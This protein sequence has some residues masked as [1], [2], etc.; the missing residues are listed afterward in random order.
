MTFSLSSCLGYVLNTTSISITFWMISVNLMD[1][2]WT[3]DDIERS[4]CLISC[5]LAPSWPLT[6]FWV[7]GT[8]SDL[9]STPIGLTKHIGTY[10]ARM[11]ASTPFGHQKFFFVIWTANYDKSLENLSRVLY[12]NEL[13]LK[14][15]LIKWYRQTLADRARKFSECPVTRHVTRCTTIKRNSAYKS[16][17]AVFSRVLLMVKGQVKFLTCSAPQMDNMLQ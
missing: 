3:G 6:S 9:A 2:L 11:P 4:V 1:V 7:I 13:I 14:C 17:E 15:K 12:I 16:A 5:Y 8:F 10:L